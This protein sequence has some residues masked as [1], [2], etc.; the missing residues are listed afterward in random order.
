[1]DKVWIEDAD[2][3]AI[4]DARM[5][6]LLSGV[7]T[8][9]PGEVSKAI[10]RGDSLVRAL[11]K[12]RGVNQQDLAVKAQLAQGYLSDIE[13]RRTPGSPEAREGIARALDVPAG[14]LR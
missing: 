3:V 11:R 4:Y 10:L 12:W 9:L 2:D 13:R 1:M 14:W 7:E 6:E 8:W 5:A